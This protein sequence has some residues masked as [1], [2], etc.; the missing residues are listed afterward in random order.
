M[1]LFFNMTIA[2]IIAGICLGRSIRAFQEM[3]RSGAKIRDKNIS[4]EESDQ[5][6][7]QFQQVHR[8]QKIY[9]SIMF[10]CYAIV[11]AMALLKL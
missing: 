5:L 7:A 9:L 1:L 10:T 4:D 6:L 2:L 11:I 3:K 8:C